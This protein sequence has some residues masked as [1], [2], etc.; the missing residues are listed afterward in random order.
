MST[1]IPTHEQVANVLRLAAHITD[2][3]RSGMS[4]YI[5]ETSLSGGA[6]PWAELLE[7]VWS[8][9]PRDEL[10]DQLAIAT[11]RIVDRDP[12]YADDSVRIQFPSNSEAEFAIRVARGLLETWRRESADEHGEKP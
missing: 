8:L 1:N 12:F 2:L 11:S 4:Y 3:D 10:L 5:R 7:A 6:S 9:R